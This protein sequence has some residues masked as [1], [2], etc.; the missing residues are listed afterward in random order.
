LAITVV[1]LPA[2]SML[3]AAEARGRI[4]EAEQA[5]NNK[6]IGLDQSLKIT[7]N[8]PLETKHEQIQI[9]T[10]VTLLT[11]NQIPSLNR[12][13]TPVIIRENL[14]A[15]TEYSLVLRELSKTLLNC[16]PNELKESFNLIY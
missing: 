3:I 1:L 4:R 16:Q 8:Q 12:Y 6:K 9:P 2:K 10:K 11:N 15:T 7:K 14:S 5:R 13:L